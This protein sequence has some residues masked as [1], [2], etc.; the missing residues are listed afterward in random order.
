MFSH[1]ESTGVGLDLP[2]ISFICFKFEIFWYDL[3]CVSCSANILLLRTDLIKCILLLVGTRHS[4]WSFPFQ[5]KELEE[6]ES[7]SYVYKTAKDK[8]SL[9]WDDSVFIY[10]I[11]V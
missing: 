1:I 5:M 6:N 2:S 8:A 3:I 10:I 7:Q 9:H 4:S 11:C